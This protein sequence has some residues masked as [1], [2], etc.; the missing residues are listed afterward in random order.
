MPQNGRAFA[1]NNR[2]Y[3]YDKIFAVA[4]YCVAY[5]IE[6]PPGNSPTL[7]EI[8][9]HFDIHTSLAA[10]YVENML[11]F[12]IAERIDGKLV[13]IGS[14]CL[15]PQWYIDNLNPPL[16]ETNQID[17][18]RRNHHIIREPLKRKV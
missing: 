5:A 7:R 10:R 14:Q 3:A 16:S 8:A 11:K 17:R 18:A 15:P 6:H 9:E 13:I 2:Q 1:K 4:T 12:G